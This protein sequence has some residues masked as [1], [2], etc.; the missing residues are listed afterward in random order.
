MRVF[1]SVGTDRHPF[2]RLVEWA[3]AWAVK[4]PEDDVLIQNGYS[5]PPRAARSVELLT[6]DE[7]TR[8]L[9]AADVLVLSAG[10][11]AVMA[12]RRAGRRPIAVPRR[13]DLGEHVDD[14]QRAFV[15][16]MDSRGLAW[17]ASNAESLDCLLRRARTEPGQFRCDPPPAGPP[18]A[19]ARFA[20]VAEL[21][22]RD[23]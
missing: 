1:V 19:V 3:E 10:P 12:A 16:H 8:E 17:A 21:V 9:A 22:A 5:D 2:D 18:A 20:E 7:M 4:N 11:G 6:H 13:S 23:R 14:H 15:E